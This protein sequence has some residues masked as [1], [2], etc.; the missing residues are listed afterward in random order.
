MK[1][2]PCT[3]PSLVPMPTGH[4][5]CVC[6]QSGWA[7]QSRSNAA[8]PSAPRSDAAGPMFTPPLALLVPAADALPAED[9]ELGH[10][11]WAVWRAYGAAAGVA[12]FVTVIVSL[13]LTQVRA[14]DPCLP[15]APCHC[16]VRRTIWQTFKMSSEASS[17]GPKWRM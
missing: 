3:A 1:A 2:L 4:R 10:V 14:L 12:L 9:R 16:V 6:L 15:A 8:E 13:A 7:L 11:R 17:F 5:L